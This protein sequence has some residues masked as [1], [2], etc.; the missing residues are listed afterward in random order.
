MF[1]LYSDVM[2]WRNSLSDLPFLQQ[3]TLYF[4]HF[5]LSLSAVAIEINLT[6]IGF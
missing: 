4:I 1:V 3:L 5:S 6:L 2:L